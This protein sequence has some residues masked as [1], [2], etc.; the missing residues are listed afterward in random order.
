MRIISPQTWCLTI[1][2][3]RVPG[4]HPLSAYH[5]VG[6]GCEIEE[7]ELAKYPLYVEPEAAGKAIAG[8]PET[9]AIEEPVKAKARLRKKGSSD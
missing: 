9:K 8:P 2:G 5:L 4:G 7:S 1:D 3:R 6:K